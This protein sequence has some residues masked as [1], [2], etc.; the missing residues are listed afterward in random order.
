MIKTIVFPILLVLGISGCERDDTVYFLEAFNDNKYYSDEIIPKD[1]QQ[2]YGKWKLTGIS[3]GFHGSGYEPDFDFLEIRSIGIYGLI[4][5]DS[6][7]E[8]G[9]IEV[10]TFDIGSVNLLK[11]ILNPDYYKGSHPYF[12]PPEKYVDISRDSL[13]LYSPCCDM[14]N[15]HFKRIK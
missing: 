6:I 14:F 1:Y 9:R 8:Y 10:D 13:A 15:F 5:H 12:F 2:I 3:G 7:F 11:I 4:R